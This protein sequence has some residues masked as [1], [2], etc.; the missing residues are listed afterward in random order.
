MMEISYRELSV[1][2]M[3]LF[4]EEWFALAS[5]NEKDGANTMTIAW[6][7]MG[8]LWERGSH[9]NRLPTVCLCP[10]NPLYKGDHGSGKPVHTIPDRRSQGAWIYRLPLRAGWGQVCRRRADTGL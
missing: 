1:N 8:S 2:P 6:G 4:G 10:S 3:T 9:A 7:H 5:G